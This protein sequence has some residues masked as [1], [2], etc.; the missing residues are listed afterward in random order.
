[1]SA[2]LAPTPRTARTSSPARI[3]R[4]PLA[5]APAPGGKRRTHSS[6]GRRI[7]LAFA[8]LETLPALSEVRLRV[9]SLTEAASVVSAD[10]VAAVESDPGLTLSVMR[11]AN[12]GLPRA[13]RLDTA[14]GAIELLGS[15]GLRALAL[16]APSFD[17]FERAGGW[18]L[19]PHQFRLHGLATQRAADRI[20]VE[21]LHPDRGRLALSSL[22]HDVGK[23]VLI[24]A[25]PGYPAQVHGAA[26]LPEER[27]HRERREL[28]VDHALAAG[29]L[30][31][32]WG[33][34]GSIAG[35]IESHHDPEGEGDAA[36]IRLA[37]MLAH[38]QHGDSVSP[39]EMSRSARAIK[40]GQSELRRLM[41]DLSGDPGQ[42][43][44]LIDPSPLSTRERRVLQ[45]LAEGSVYK[46]I[47]LQLNLSASTVRSHL[48]KIYRKL[49]ARDRAQAVLIAS[50][51]GWL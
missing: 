3:S 22:L 50:R 18:D 47:A 25:Y 49:G 24:R 7:A 28:G 37:D 35:P 42:R 36:V 40:L 14:S 21:I 16:E 38:Y 5:P 30:L 43:R 34:P 2:S 27:I 1:M 51:R 20:A 15:S 31:R 17:F 32:R 26:H 45:G 33:L 6:H 9:L 48:N 41:G 12:A 19:A 44:K 8:E 23:L 11:A 29:V 10:L 46:E 4:R 13:Q 39:V